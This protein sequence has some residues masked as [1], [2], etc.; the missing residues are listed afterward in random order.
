[1]RLRL[2][3]VIVIILFFAIAP[4]FAAPP[5]AAP[6]SNSILLRPQRVF[7]GASGVTHDGWVVLVTGEKIAAA[8]PATI[9]L[10]VGTITIDLPGMTLL[11]GLI[12]A[13]SHIFLHP[14]N[15][16]LWNE[17]VL[18]EPV[19][20]RTIAA[21]LH[22]RDTLLAGF[23]TLRDLGTE[24]AGFADVAVKR[25]IDEG[26]I[27]G[28]H[29]FVATRAI[30]ATASYG[31][32]PNGFAPE[33]DPLT[34][35]GQEASGTAEILRA[36][37][38]QI[39]HG[40]DWVKVY[41]D[42]GRGSSPATPTFSLDELKTLVDEAHSAGRPVAA[43][44]TTPE[45]MRRAIMAGVDTIEHGY[46]GTDEVFKLMAAHNV[47][48]LPTLAAEEAYSEYFQSYK[49][50]TKPYTASMENVLR[51]FKLALA[52]NVII[53]CGSDVGVFTH[54]DNYRELEWMVRAGMT[55]A[56][57]LLAATS[58][59]AKILNQQDHLGRIAPGLLADLIAVP[60][61]PTHDI[62]TIEHVPFVMKGGRVFV[63]PGK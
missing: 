25:A 19:A 7:D 41:A 26:R 21:T 55:P 18:T 49:R 29:L 16:T 37:R 54:G 61:D 44:A 36:V 30:V 4:V 50:G 56:Q 46:G 40:A 3:P 1:M 11:P 43:H 22:A 8:G 15:E 63:Q 39:G 10:P 28:P 32:G 53:G 13:H 38:E 58:V 9:A 57:A 24:G 34:K 6:P 42:Y 59:D 35:G 31:P 27:P 14:Y 5:N 2:T 51:A 47:A 60:G 17:Q 12:D 23:T 52:N 45:G 48:Y 20:Y 62:T 33:F